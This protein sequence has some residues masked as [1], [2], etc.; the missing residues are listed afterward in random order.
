[1]KKLD[2][3]ILRGHVSFFF[4]VFSNQGLI[5]G[6]CQYLRNLPLPWPNSY[7]NLLSIDYHWV[8]EGVG[9]CSVAQILIL[10]PNSHHPCFLIKQSWVSWISYKCKHPNIKTAHVLCERSASPCA[11]L[12]WLLSLCCHRHNNSCHSNSTWSSWSQV[13]A[14]NFLFMHPRSITLFSNNGHL[15]IHKACKI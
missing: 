6:Q 1:M 4:F 5:L 14:S 13:I 2:A 9:R 15:F 8:R 10:I 7:P 11:N 3:L 12:V